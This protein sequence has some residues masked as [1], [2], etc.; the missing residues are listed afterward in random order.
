MQG[1]LGLFSEHSLF[2]KQS[3]D[4]ATNSRVLDAEKEGDIFICLFKCLMKFCP[5]SLKRGSGDTSFGFWEREFTGSRADD[6]YI[7]LLDDII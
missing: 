2:C 1:R 5:H 6:T 7:F 3:I 4:S